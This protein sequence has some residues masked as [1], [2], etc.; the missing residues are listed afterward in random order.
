VTHDEPSRLPEAPD[1]V[2][3]EGR[4]ADPDDPDPADGPIREPGE[5]EAPIG[6]P[7]E[8]AEAPDVVRRTGAT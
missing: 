7:G 6:F 8:E 1:A 3:E 4:R 2:E 5:G